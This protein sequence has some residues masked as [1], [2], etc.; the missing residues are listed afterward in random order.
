MSPGV[1]RDVLENM[2]LDLEDRD[3]ITLTF[4]GGEPALAGL[5]WYE[6]FIQIFL[7]VQ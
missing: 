1:R 6:E 3:E 5:T 7:S 2:V 4:H